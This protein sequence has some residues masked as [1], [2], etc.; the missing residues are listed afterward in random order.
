[1][2]IDPRY[3]TAKTPVLKD[4]TVVFTTK[5]G[6]TRVIL[7][8][9]ETD[10]G[11]VSRAIRDVSNGTAIAYRVERIAIAKKEYQTA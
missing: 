5:M 3:K 8:Q 2:K 11:A 10:S 6:E 4:I 9:H 1:M 7:T